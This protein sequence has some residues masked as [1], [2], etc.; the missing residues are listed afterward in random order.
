MAQENWHFL[1][2]EEGMAIGHSP[3]AYVTLC[4]FFLKQRTRATKE[5]A[6]YFLMVTL[7]INVLGFKQIFLARGYLTAWAS[8]L[9]DILSLTQ[10]HLD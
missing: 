7:K 9:R 8:V 5:R 3:A 2:K 10:A 6:Y 4:C 1:I